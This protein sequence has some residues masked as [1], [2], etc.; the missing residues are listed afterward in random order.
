MQNMLCGLGTAL[1]AWLDTKLILV[2]RLSPWYKIFQWKPRDLIVSAYAFIRSLHDK[3]TLAWWL[4]HAWYCF[5]D[6]ILHAFLFTCLDFIIQF[7]VNLIIIICTKLQMDLSEFFASLV[8]PRISL[9]VRKYFFVGRSFKCLRRESLSKSLETACVSFYCSHILCVSCAPTSL[10][11]Y[12]DIIL[13][14]WSW[15]PYNM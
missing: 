6:T 10:C 15:S 14:L 13:R 3:Y 9:V 4:G 1:Q 12:H 8:F 7:S 2:S 11:L 5:S